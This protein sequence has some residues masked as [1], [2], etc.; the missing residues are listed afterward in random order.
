MSFLLFLSNTFF[1]IFQYSS[2]TPNNPNLPTGDNTVLVHTPWWVYLL[3]ALAIAA[4][5]YGFKKLIEYRSN[6]DAN[7]DVTAGNQPVVV[8]EYEDGTER[9]F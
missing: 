9:R 6:P 4:V 5:I 3:S 2:R 7:K 1:A 8:S